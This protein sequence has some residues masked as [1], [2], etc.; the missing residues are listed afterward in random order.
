MP[1]LAP[2]DRPLALGP[3][4]EGAAEDVDETLNDVAV[5]ESVKMAGAGFTKAL[6]LEFVCVILK[7]LLYEVVPW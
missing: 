7:K 3:P 5:A 4:P 2:P 1:T 6:T